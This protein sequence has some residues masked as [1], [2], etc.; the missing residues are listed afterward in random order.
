MATD[1]DFDSM[2][3][4]EFEAF[5]RTTLMAP[6][7][8]AEAMQDTCQFIRGDVIVE[9]AVLP[10]FGLLSM[11][12]NRTPMYCY[13]HPELKKR[14]PK[15]F[16]DGK[17]IYVSDDHMRELMAAEDR[18]KGTKEGVV[19]LILH[20]LLHMVMNHH[21]RF[22]A[23][24]P[25]I[26]AI[27]ADISVYAKLKLAYPTMKWVDELERDFVASGLSTP[28]L[29]K[30]AKLAEESI[31]RELGGRYRSNLPGEDN[32]EFD[33]EEK[34]KQEAKERK[35]R[36]AK[37]RAEKKE[38]KEKERQE[39][40]EKKEKEKEK[41]DPSDEDGDPEDAEEADQEE[42]ADADQE[43][44]GDGEPGD[45]DGEPGE[46]EG[47]PSDEMGEG[48]RP[49]KNKGALQ[50]AL[51]EM[52]M[53]DDVDDLDSP[54]SVSLQEMAQIMEDE[55]LSATQERLDMP[56]P[57]EYDKAQEQER[58]TRAADIEDI[59]KSVKMAGK[60]GTMGGGHLAGS[61]H[62][63]VLK[64][65]EGKLSWKLGLQEILG[66]SMK[67]GY[68]EEEPGALYFVDPKDMGLETEIYIGA[69]LPKKQEGAVMVLM[70]SSGSITEPLFKMFLAEVFGIIRNEN[71]ESS[72]A[73]EVVLLFC[74]DVLRGDPIIITEENYEDLMKDKI[75]ISGRGGNDIGG[76][77]KAA[78][79][80]DM[81]IDKQINAIIYFTDLGDQ[82]PV[83]S[84]CPE[85]VP[86]VFVCP[87]EYYQE[88]FIKAVKDFARVYPIEEGMEVDLTR[89]GYL[90]NEPKP[91]TA[92]KRGFG[93][94]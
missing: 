2:T 81:F 38:R 54:H 5:E 55:G 57:W 17:H 87:P 40:K 85:F 19:P 58:A 3:D 72:N 64:E 33:E 89:G 80:L 47:E 20:H 29:Q 16:N 44:E 46:G 4:E 68:S 79:K 41:K 43:A 27:G 74:D 51:R 91:K 75:K 62:E 66:A 59:T 92:V 24:D 42:D 8:M 49:S 9:G 77:I 63:E 88:E 45:G 67:Y 52:G 82:P 56:K 23:Y 71:P 70:D 26:A 21:K 32:E 65:T 60:A 78:S 36:E 61:A 93:G 53:N 28:E 18:S 69:D 25:D 12:A 13:G 76:T 90:T 83:K 10:R 35:E 86:L 15:S 50:Q 6:D 84:D 37:E 39:K 14:F 30:Y 34:Q 31:I 7:D 48:G 94:W 22:N 1:I 11:K 73:S